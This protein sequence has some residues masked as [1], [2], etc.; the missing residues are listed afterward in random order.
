MGL[1]ERYLRAVAAQLPR[2]GR[3]DIVDELRDE[4]AARMEA[5]EAA[6]GRPLDEAEEEAVLREMGHPLTVATRYRAGPQHLVGPELYPWWLFAVKAALLALVALGAI[7]LAARVLLGEAPFGQALGQA[8]GDLVGGGLTVVGLA[9]VAA[10]LLERQASR[11][12]FMTEWRVRDLGVFEMAGFDAEDLGVR[13]AAAGR[14]AGA[15]APAAPGRPARM[16]PT[17]RA[18]ASAAAWSVFLLWWVGLLPLPAFRPEELAAAGGIELFEALAETVAWLW[19]PIVAY[20]AARVAF[21]LM[22]AASG[23]HV[24]LTAAGDLAFAVAGLALVAW[25][26]T[27]SP[28]APVIDIAGPAEWLDRAERLVMTGAWGLETVLWVSLSF[29]FLADLWRVGRSLV[30][31][32]TGRDGGEG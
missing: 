1:T 25:L 19:W 9:T 12:R 27:A 20:A 2:E 18:L 16:S 14:A 23:G 6:L 28:L 11:P 30:R 17:A 32:A 26:W 15:G 24:R 8:M 21:D 29:A 13:V 3:E 4:L 5:R 10:Y 22:R 31:L 7:G